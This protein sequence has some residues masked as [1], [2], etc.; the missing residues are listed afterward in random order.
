ME[1]GD[2]VMLAREEFDKLINR[3]SDLVGFV[4]KLV[5][6][7][8]TSHPYHDEIVIDEAYLVNLNSYAKYLHESLYDT[9]LEV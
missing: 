8:T 4:Y 7:Y 1:S 2:Y 6:R 5:D 3:A 9:G